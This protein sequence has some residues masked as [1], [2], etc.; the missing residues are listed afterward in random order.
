MNYS[1]D[2]FLR[3]LEEVE[4]QSGVHL[5]EP[6][7]ARSWRM[8]QPDAKGDMRWREVFA[9]GCGKDKRFA[10]PYEPAATSAKERQAMKERGAG[11]VYACAVDDD[12]GKWPRFAEAGILPSTKTDEGS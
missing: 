5:P 8:Q 10:V 11:F 1:P 12:M 7:T 4:R 3:L 2:D 6:C 9:T